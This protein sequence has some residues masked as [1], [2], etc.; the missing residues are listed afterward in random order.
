VFSESSRE[1]RRMELRGVRS[2]WDILAINS[3]LY[4]VVRAS[5]SDPVF[6]M[7][8]LRMRNELIFLFQGTASLFQFLVG[9]H[10][11]FLLVLSALLRRPAISPSVLPAFEVRSPA[12]CAGTGASSD[13]ACV[14]SSSSCNLLRVSMLWTV[15]PMFSLMLVKNSRSRAV[16]SPKSPIR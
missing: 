14:S 4:L 15:V 7:S 13:W 3:D 10:Q 1:S 2:S 5:S 16:Y 9:L 12:R 8:R 6:C 11:L